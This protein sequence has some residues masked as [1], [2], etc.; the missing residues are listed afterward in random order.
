MTR[1]TILLNSLRTVVTNLNRI[2][3]R[4]ERKRYAM[5]IPVTCFGDILIHDVVVR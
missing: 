4:I 3:V 2:F 5:V 1:N